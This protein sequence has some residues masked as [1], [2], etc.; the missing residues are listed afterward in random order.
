MC[1][2]FLLLWASEQVLSDLGLGSGFWRSL[3]FPQSLTIDYSHDLTIIWQK[4]WWKTK[5]LVHKGNTGVQ[6]GAQI[7]A[8]HTKRLKRVYF[9]LSRRQFMISRRRLWSD[10]CGDQRIC[11][12][13][14]R[15]STSATRWTCSNYSRITW[16]TMTSSASWNSMGTKMGTYFI[17][18]VFPRSTYLHNLTQSCAFRKARARHW[19]L[20]HCPGQVEFENYSCGASENCILLAP[21]GKYVLYISGLLLRM[22]AGFVVCHP[23]L[24]YKI[25]FRMPEPCSS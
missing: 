3:R 15:A 1:A 10:W 23:S 8:S 11:P 6:N 13:R 12:H 24:S 7:C 16:P 14:W 4:K 19:C 22:C 25:C 9:P 2:T 5:F 21:L 18:W 20:P 17:R